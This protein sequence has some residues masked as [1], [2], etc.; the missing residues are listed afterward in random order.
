MKLS[1]LL[2]VGA[3]VVGGLFVARNAHTWMN[4][5]HREKA[6]VIAALRN[7]F[8]DEKAHV[9]AQLKKGLDH[10]E[11]NVRA[12]LKKRLARERA[13]AAAALKK[14]RDRERARAADARRAAESHI[15][16]V[17]TPDSAQTE[18]AATGMNEAAFWGLM[19]ETRSAA[20]NDTGKQSELLKARLT[21]LS[22]T[23][24]IEFARVRH[25]LDQAAYTWD[26]WG[27]AQ[28]IEDG[29]S[30]DCFRNFRGYLI[31]LGEGPYVNALSNPDSLAP[32][33]QDAETGNWE[34]ADNVAPD[35]YSSVTGGDFPLGDS[36]VSGSPRG[37]PFNEDDAAGLAR[38]YP[39]LAARFR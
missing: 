34:S 35:A 18:N 14:R 1:T 27:A 38:R 31:S 32:V 33:V 24:I 7:R 39:R 11:A 15:P 2:V 6:H 20:G 10:E 23:A 4:D 16:S 5:L 30:D 25:R 17:S 29:C 36:D 21:Q 13:R 19:S 12:E 26:L 37:T 9:T 8:E 28:V 3:L 22:P